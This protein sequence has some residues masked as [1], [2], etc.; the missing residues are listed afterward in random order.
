MEKFINLQIHIISLKYESDLWIF[1]E[2]P[3]LT[4]LKEIKTRTIIN[5]SD[6]SSKTLACT[7]QKS[8]IQNPQTSLRPP[9]LIN[10]RDKL[11]YSI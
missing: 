8:L 2:P 4:T 1:Q 11:F 5:S 7:T 6:N 9:R 10:Q 3:L